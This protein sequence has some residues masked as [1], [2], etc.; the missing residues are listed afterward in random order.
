MPQALTLEEKKARAEAKAQERNSTTGSDGRRRKN[1]FNGTDGKLKIG[2]DIPGYHLHII[3]DTP[4]RIDAAIDNGYEF[5][6]PDEVGGVG[7]N[8]VSRNTAVEGDK[9]RF[10]VGQLE[11][12]PLYAYLMK[13]K[14]E[15]WEEDQRALQTRNNQIDAA[16]KQGQ[17]P[18]VTTDGF[19]SK[20]IKMEN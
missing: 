9:V 7:N 1:V 8:T 3:N 2:H 5:V 15:W 10:L 14:Q 12:Q 13:I 18:G 16:I 11:G 4:G 6:S 17:T 19:Y 20:G